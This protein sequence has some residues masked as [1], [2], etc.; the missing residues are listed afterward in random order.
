M[1]ELNVTEPLSLLNVTE[2]S[3]QKGDTDGD[4]RKV[5]QLLKGNVP[6]SIS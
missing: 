2:L 3:S 6:M 5:W 4:S 1:G